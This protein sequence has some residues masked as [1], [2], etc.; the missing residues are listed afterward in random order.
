MA[1]RGTTALAI[2]RASGAVSLPNT[3]PALLYAQ[4]LAAQGPGFAADSYLAGSGIAIPSGRLKPGTRYALVFDVSKTAAGMTTPILTLRFGIAG[5]LAD[6]ALGALTFPVQTA[7]AD[8]GRVSLEVTFRSVGASA[9]VQAVAALGHAACRRPV[10]PMCRSGEARDL[11]SLRCH[12]GQCGDR[13]IGEWRCCGG[14][15]GVAGAG[16]LGEPRMTTLERDVGALEAR[17]QTVEMEIQ[18]MRQDVREIRDA[19][20]TARGGWKTLTLVIGFSITFGAL[21][22]RVMHV[23]MMDR[24]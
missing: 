13:H 20:V 12:G 24:I 6:A 19:L 8:D 9:V 15:D 3:P 7:V 10:F 4:A 5:S 14:M 2:D 16:K 1:R 17:M 18:A 23:L 21:L 11:R 22:S